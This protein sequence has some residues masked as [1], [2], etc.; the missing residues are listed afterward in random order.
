MP[1]G[2]WKAAAKARAA[3][4]AMTI[5]RVA[6]QLGNIPLSLSL[7]I[8]ENGLEWSLHSGSSREE[9]MKTLEVIQVKLY[10][11]PPA[12]TSPSTP[13]PRPLARSTVT[14]RVFF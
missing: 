4:A 13:R 6:V 8:G 10:A 1:L 3:A 2:A 12:T 5:A 14:C 11:T 9:R 7:C